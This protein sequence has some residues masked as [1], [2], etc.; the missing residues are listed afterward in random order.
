MAETA[1]L[2][3]DYS[4]LSDLE[5]RIRLSDI[6]PEIMAQVHHE[7]A[8]RL[9]QTVASVDSET[10]QTLVAAV[11][12]AR[13]F[14]GDFEQ[15]I[16]I[17]VLT[18]GQ[19]EQ[20]RQQPPEV[21]L[22]L[23][24]LRFL[25][26]DQP[27]C[28]EELDP[29]KIPVNPLPSLFEGPVEEVAEKIKGKLLV[30]EDQSLIVAETLAQTPESNERWIKAGK[31]IFGDFPVD[32]FAANYR[33]NPMLFLRSSERDSCVRIVS[34]IDPSTQTPFI[35]PKQVCNHLGIESGQLFQL[36]TRDTT[37]NLLPY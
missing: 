16:S 19:L 7:I 1:Q 29:D 35:N 22:G 34:G 33:G 4:A 20:A 31:P 17:G 25:D 13:R 2:L 10:R 9:L 6:D 3:E 5:A 27:R 15:L 26:A 23:I 14:L 12:R 18:Q 30:F 28:L 37:I 11:P 32:A 36:T 24:A 21:N 8:G